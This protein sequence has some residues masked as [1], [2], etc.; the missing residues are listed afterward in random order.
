M[1]DIFSRKVLGITAG[2]SDLGGMQWELLGTLVMAWLVVY[3]IIMKGLHAS[4]KVNETNNCKLLTK[5]KLHQIV[6]FTALFPYFVIITLL[7]KVC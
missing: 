7:F 5:C 1:L 6:W 3:L 2:I 4:G